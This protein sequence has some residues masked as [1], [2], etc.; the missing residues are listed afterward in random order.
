MK[1]VLDFTAVFLPCVVIIGLPI[2]FQDDIYSTLGGAGVPRPLA[3]VGLWLLQMI[4]A[5]DVVTRWALWLSSLKPFKFIAAGPEQFKHLDREQL[6]RQTA[7]LEQLGFVQLMDYTSPVPIGGTAPAVRLFAHP[8][9][10][11]F[12]TVGATTQYPTCC[13]SSFLEQDWELS[14]I[15]V[16]P[17]MVGSSLYGFHYQP[18][19]LFKILDQASPGTMFQTLLDW[20]SAVTSNLG[21]APVPN[22]Q[23]EGYFANEQKKRMKHL[24]TLVFRKSITWCVLKMFWAMLI[25][26]TEW[27]GDYKKYQ[28]NRSR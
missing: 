7:E 21:I 4:L 3:I 24:N 26:Q 13:I 25:P 2:W 20:R 17:R 12:A 1:T 15:R 10:C 28:G 5:W 22:H 27:L 23:A 16:S 19:Q 8:E 11:C 14:V 9:Q 6:D 18:R